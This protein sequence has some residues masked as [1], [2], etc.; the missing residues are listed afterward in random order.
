MIKKLTFLAFLVVSFSANANEELE[1]Q[2]LCLQVISLYKVEIK[3][4]GIN[5]SVIDSICKANTK[6]SEYWSC[7]LSRMKKGES[8][9]YATGQCEK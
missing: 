9:G 5:S 4:K 8:F 6:P 3:N 2:K 7:S 1:A